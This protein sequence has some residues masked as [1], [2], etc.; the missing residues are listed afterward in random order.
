LA[1]VARLTAERERKAV[2]FGETETAWRR[3]IIEAT[4][5][6]SDIEV[7]E[8]AHITR[9]RVYQIRKGRRT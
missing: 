3:A 5:V 4:Q 6:H 7:A 8:V 2:E 9:G 1:E